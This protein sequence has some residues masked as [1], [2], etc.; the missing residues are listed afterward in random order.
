MAAPLEAIINIIPKAH[1]RTAAGQMKW[2]DV[3]NRFP[4]FVMATF[5]LNDGFSFAALPGNACGI[6]AGGRT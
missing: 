5:F 1:R 4:E 6:Q 2:A 3:K